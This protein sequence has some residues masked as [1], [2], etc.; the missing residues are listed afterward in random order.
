MMRKISWLLALLCL[1][2]VSPLRAEP[3]PVYTLLLNGDRVERDPPPLLTIWLNGNPIGIYTSDRS[4]AIQVNQFIKKGE[5]EL[6]LVDAGHRTWTVQFALVNPVNNDAD[7]ILDQEISLSGKGEWSTTLN[8]PKVDWTLPIF[9]S[10]IGEAQAANPDLPKYLEDLF[11][12]MMAVEKTPVVSQIWKDGMAIWIK[13][14][15]GQTDQM[16]SGGQTMLATMLENVEQLQDT[17]SREKTKIIRGRNIVLVYNG[18]T[19]DQA[20]VVPYLGLWKNKDGSLGR[21]P[22]TILYR[23]KDGWAVWQ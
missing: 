5:N 22:P 9:E 15:Y 17:P 8:L 19:N 7:V 16:I 4:I 10:H 6:K 23:T 21:V 14:A 11:R 2:A 1:A 18:I 3:K 12:G 20:G 13:N